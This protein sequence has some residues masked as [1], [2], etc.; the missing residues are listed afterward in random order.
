VQEF[1]IWMNSVR[2]EEQEK[3]PRKNESYQHQEVQRNPE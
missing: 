2:G 1:S 3:F